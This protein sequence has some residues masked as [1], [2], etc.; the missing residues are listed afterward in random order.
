VAF[1]SPLQFV[2]CFSVKSEFPVNSVFPDVNRA[3]GF[4]EDTP[5]MAYQEMS[6]AAPILLSNTKTF[7]QETLMNGSIVI[8]QQTPDSELLTPTG[9][10]IVPRQI[11][12]EKKHRKEEIIPDPAV[13]LLIAADVLSETRPS[14]VDRYVSFNLELYVITVWVYDEPSAPLFHL[15]F[16]STW[17]FQ[18]LRDCIARAAGFEY[19][20]ETDSMDFY[21]ANGRGLPKKIPIRTADT[22]IT[23]EFHER[24][25]EKNFVFVKLHRSLPE[26]ELARF[27]NVVVHVAHDGYVV[28]LK[29][30]VRYRM[31]DQLRGL[32]L[33]LRE[34]GAIASCEHVRVVEEGQHKMQ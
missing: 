16:L 25:S 23:F 9:I 2:S 21:L 14:T 19:S 17:S 22:T 3:V 11:V 8:F 32:L 15:K 10:E 26:A 5:L 24:Y 7:D 13:R 12:P 27:T 34:M 18:E 1:D 20:S 33:A 4:P 31:D 29:T 6:S 30:V 28:D